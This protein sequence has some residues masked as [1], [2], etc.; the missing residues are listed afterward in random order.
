M[1]LRSIRSQLLGLVVATVV[2]FTALIGIGLSSQWQNDQAAAIQRAMND[3]R[4]V[5]A[6]VDDYIG[7][8]DNLL[9]GLTPAVSSNPA[10]TAANDVLLRQLKVEL[11]T[12]ISNVMV[13]APKGSNIGTSSDVGRFFYGDRPHFIRALTGQRL[14]IG[15]VAR[16][17]AGDYWVVSVARPVMDK[18]G[19]VKAVLVAGTHLDH[20]QDALRVKELPAGSVVEVISQDGIVVA[21]IPDGANWIGRNVGADAGEH[22]PHL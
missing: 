6:Q 1:L 13:F 8:V 4:L 10:D 18:S 17:R 12:Y 7:N 21:R 22:L 20:F 2:P 16:A 15:D 5:A 3:A 11:P 9:T 19:K 14:V